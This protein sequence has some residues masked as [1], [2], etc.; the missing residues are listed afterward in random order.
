MKIVFSAKG[1]A[2]SQDSED[3]RWFGTLVPLKADQQRR[4]VTFAAPNALRAARGPKPNPAQSSKR[5]SL[6]PAP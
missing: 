2:L 4:K 3:A 6:V 1:P 5:M